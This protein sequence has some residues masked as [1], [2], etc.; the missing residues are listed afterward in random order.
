MAARSPPLDRRVGLRY[1][2]RAR[3]HAGNFQTF[4]TPLVELFEQRGGCGV[5]LLVV[6]VGG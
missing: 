1:I 5:C 4:Q 3:V 6:M 2:V